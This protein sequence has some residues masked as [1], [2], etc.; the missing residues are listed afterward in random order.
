MVCGLKNE[1]T[2]PRLL[3]LLESEYVPSD[4]NMVTATNPET[5]QRIFTVDGENW[6]DIH[7]G[8]IIE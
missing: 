2:D 5:G 7:T 3:E 8:L 4:G 1:I 6:R